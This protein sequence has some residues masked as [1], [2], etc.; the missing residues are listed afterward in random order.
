[1]TS[2]TT[3]GA[4]PGVQVT[5]AGGAIT[6]VAIGREQKL[7]LTG[8]GD[9]ANA[10]A[11]ANTATQISSR[12]QADDEFGSGSELAEAMKDALANGANIDFLYGVL[13]DEVSV[14]G[15]TFSNTSS[16]TL[17]NGPIIEDTSKISVQDTTNNES[18]SVE[19]RYD[20]P[21]SQPSA[22]NTMF[23]NP[24]TREWSA[25]EAADYDVDYEYPD[26]TAGLDEAETV[27]DV[28]E[29]GILANLA[30]SETIASDLSG[31]LNTLRGNYKMAMGVQ[32]AEP[33]T[34]FSTDNDAK[35]DTGSYSDSIDNDAMFLHAP[36]REE[37]SKF[38]ITGGFA[39]V[40]AGNDLDESIYESLT[41][42]NLDQRLSSS[43]ANDLRDEEV[44]PVIQPSSGGSIEIEDNRSTSQ[45]TDWTRDYFT[46][47][48]VD[49]VI[50]IAKT[51]GDS[52]IGRINDQRTRDAVQTQIEVELRGLAQ[53]RLIK[54]NE[55]LDQGNENWFVD[56]YEVD[57]NEVGVDIGVTPYGIAKRVN[58]SITINTA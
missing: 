30:E 23:I 33:N 57:A 52:V 28:E 19:F 58:T 55:G 1:M 26:W 37:D 50:L 54:S 3:Y 6:G 32:S 29:T 36:G 15:E 39:G 13:L 46:R 53:D 35:F 42:D 7:V 56:V 10:N 11:S 25:D 48:I 14:T 2:T 24:I 40:M 51:I 20:Q 31:R 45:N 41:V 12:A 34:T 18:V 47:R 5:T 16:G 17:A 43:E 49:Q 44:I 9:Q 21:P 38:L 8:V 4:F 27:I 22:S